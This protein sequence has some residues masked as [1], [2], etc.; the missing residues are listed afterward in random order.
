[1]WCIYAQWNIIQPWEKENPAICDNM[2]G[3]WGFY[4]KWDITEKDKYCLV[5]E[6]QILISLVCGI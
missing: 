2:F 1:M 3:A 4:A 6:R 5:F